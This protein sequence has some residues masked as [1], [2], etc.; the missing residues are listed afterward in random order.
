[1]HIYIIPKEN[2][3]VR[4]FTNQGSANSIENSTPEYQLISLEVLLLR[5]AVYATKIDETIKK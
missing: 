1:M 3:N 4:I 5:V 2:L